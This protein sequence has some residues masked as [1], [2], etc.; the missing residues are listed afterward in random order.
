MSCS[1]NPQPLS[2]VAGKRR[3]IRCISSTENV[4]VCAG[5]LSRGTNC[6]SQEFPED[7]DQSGQP[8]FGERLGRVELL[9]QK[10]LD[11]VAAYETV[12]PPATPESMGNDVLTPYSS[13]GLN[14]NE[15]HP[16][17]SLFDNVVVS[18]LSHLRPTG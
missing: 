17:L 8:Q 18:Y 11:K 15:N 14:A 2:N 13:N 1:A 9:L 12:T 5:C 16:V 6:V 3:K 7:H 10:L 4:S